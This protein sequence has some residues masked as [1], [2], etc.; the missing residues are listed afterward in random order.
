M[1]VKDIVLTIAGV[2]YLV[3]SMINN[4]TNLKSAMVYKVI[5]LFIG[6]I[7]LYA[8]WAMK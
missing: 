4:T 6:L 5:P 2:Y 7:C 1:N 8:A 3:F